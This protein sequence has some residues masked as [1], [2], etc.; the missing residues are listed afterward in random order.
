MLFHETCSIK[1]N[2]TLRVLDRRDDGYHDIHSLFWR[3]RSPESL[4]VCT[5]VPCDAVSVSGAEIPGENI[6]SRCRDYLRRQ[7]GSI[8]PSALGIRVFKRL[9][10]G[11]GVGAGSGNAAALFKWFT[12]AV[13]RVEPDTINL[14]ELGAD[15]AFLCGDA[16]LALAGGVGERLEALD[17]SL[18]LSAAIFF[19]KWTSNTKEAYAALDRARGEGLAHP[20]SESEA[21]AE[22]VSILASLRRGECVGLLPNDFILCFPEHDICYNGFYEIVREFGALAWGLCGSGSACFAL[23]DRKKSNSS[24][25]DA[26]SR[27]GLGS[28]CKWLEDILI[29]E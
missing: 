14:S 9:P 26:I 15:V 25:A 4:E 17:G 27:I 19:P 5:G 1:I 16:D 12:H 7:Y 2:L 3:L 24:M 6:V 23:F 22:S 8:V 21:R 18:D 28:D 29:L 10:M 20:V 11:S 13:S